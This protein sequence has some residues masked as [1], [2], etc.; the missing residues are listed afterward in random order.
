MGV[1][2]RA[3]VSLLG[4]L[5]VD[6]SQILIFD[7]NDPQADFRESTALLSENPGTLFVSPGV[8]L[9]SPWI[10]KAAASGIKISS[11]LSL[12]FSLLST[13]RVI[14]ITGSIGKST[15][16]SLLG[17]GAMALSK[18][19]FVGGN[20]GTPLAVY[21]GDLVLGL[22]GPAPFVILELSSYQLENFENLVC[23]FSAITYLT[24]NH[25]ERYS[26]LADY[27][28]TKLKLISNTKQTCV[29]N[30]NG[31]ELRQWVEK[32]YAQNPKLLWTDRS[33]S[34]LTQ[35]QLVP[36]SL[37]GE[38]NKDNLALAAE[39]ASLASFPP[40]S[41]TKMKIF[42]GLSHRL[43]NLGLIGSVQFINDSKATTIESVLQATKTVCE[44]LS[45]E[46]R[47][48]LF[49]GG[50]DKN[51]PWELLRPL[52]AQKQLHF[53]FFGEFGLSAK[54]I[55]GLS[56][57]CY[58]TLAIALGELPGLTKS[59]DTVLFSPG[60]TSHDEFKNFEERGHFFKTV[61]TRLFSSQ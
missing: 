30:S 45:S 34:L 39:I 47:L 48:F 49:L 13:E 43:E 41:F 23:D 36:C 8:P 7:E 37:V 16:T 26:S 18:D 10:V 22:R 2:G 46:A 29:L 3:L 27:Y 53:V 54:K 17:A 12:S 61:V 58:P 19:C 11:E 44:T 15:V 4:T 51:L 5:G 21:A 9:S 55:T 25:L 59:G 14:A 33:S 32:T 50:H 52:A 35:Q 28:Q 56:G 20:L 40:E 42:K 24:P 6:E 1:T 57:P 60:G 38:Y 31:G